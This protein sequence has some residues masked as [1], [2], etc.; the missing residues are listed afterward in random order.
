MMTKKWKHVRCRATNVEFIESESGKF[1]LSRPIQVTYSVGEK[2]GCEEGTDVA[3][4]GITLGDSEGEMVGS[5]VG[6][7]VTLGTGVG[8]LDGDDDGAGDAD[9]SKLTEGGGV[10][11]LDGAL[12]GISAGSIVGRRVGRGVDP[13]PC[14]TSLPSSPQK[15]SLRISERMF[16]G[17]FLLIFFERFFFEI[18]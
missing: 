13:S 9:G 7:F 2:V 3:V 14:H 12:V 11:I 16:F 15:M 17:K 1:N 10:G 18:R 4:V 6:G 5:V 8:K